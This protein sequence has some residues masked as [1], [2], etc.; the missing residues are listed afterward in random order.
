MN[1]A[2]VTL[3]SSQGTSSLMTAAFSPGMLLQHTDLEQ[4]NVYTRDLSRL[5]FKSLFG[6]GVVCGLEVT[7]TLNCGRLKITV[8]AG[9]A[10]SCSGD[11]IYVPQPV[12]I[13]FDEPADE[14]K[15]PL[16]VVL[17]RKVKQCAPRSSNCCSEDDDL[18][19]ACTRQREG[20]E[21]QV[22]SSRP[23][24]V[25]GC[26][27]QAPNKPERDCQCADPTLECYQDHYLGKCGCHCG[28]GS[29]C[30]CICILLARLDRPKDKVP[31]QADHRV[32]RFVR[33]VLMRDPIKLIPPTPPAPTTTGHEAGGTAANPDET[34]S[35]G[36][37]SEAT[38]GG[39]TSVEEHE[40]ESTST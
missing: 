23:P 25:C 1:K 29:D 12:S 36:D 2:N 22:V 20:Y 15:D 17:R 5:L 6:C 32:R 33:P 40:P 4:L 18:P 13:C 38:V 11:P 35:G 19:S 8:S 37:A 21:L 9:V 3:G 10:L 39:E 26:S 27:G 7:P 16:W 14:K 30:E 34:N 24:C 28:D 31:W